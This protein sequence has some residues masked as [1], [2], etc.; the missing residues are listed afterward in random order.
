MLSEAK[1]E[2]WNGGPETKGEEVEE[3][4]QEGE[5]QGGGRKSR[6]SDVPWV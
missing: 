4:S 5:L 3:A 6:A 1:G 2:R